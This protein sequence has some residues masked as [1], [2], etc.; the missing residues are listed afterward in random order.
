MLAHNHDVVLA[1]LTDENDT[2]STSTRRAWLGRQIADVLPQFDLTRAGT[3]I[4]ERRA[5]MAVDSNGDEMLGHAG[6][7]LGGERRCVAAGED[8]QRVPR[9]TT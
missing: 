9:S 5:G 8:R 6:V 3:T 4:H 2:S 7:L 1:A